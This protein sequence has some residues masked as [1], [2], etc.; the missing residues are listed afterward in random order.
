MK[1]YW[2]IPVVIAALG[3]TGCKNQEQA[4]PQEEQ[5]A[6]VEVDT[7]FNTQNL[8]LAEPLKY[9]VLFN[10]GDLVK[11]PGKDTM[12]TQKDKNDFMAYLPIDGSSTHGWLWTN[13]EEIVNDDNLLDGGGATLLEIERKDGGEWSVIGTPYA[14]D[15]GPVHGT[16]NN[17]LGGVTPWGNVI[18]SE[19]YEPWSNKEI[20]REGK[21]VRDT[22]DLEGYPRYMSYGWMVEVDVKQK[23][24]LR[25]LYAMG[26][27]SHEGAL[28]MPDGK[29]V[30][31]MDDEAPG[32]FFKFVADKANDYAEGQLYAYQQ[33]E[34]LQSGT[35]LEMPRSR[36]SLNYARD[37]ALKRGATVFIRLE[38]I[39]QAGDGRFILTETGRD[40]ADLSRAVALGGKIAKHNLPFVDENHVL[41]DYH[42]RILVFD[43][44]TNKVSTLL[45]GG[46]AA[47]ASYKVM[48]NPDNLSINLK[49]NLLVI[50]ED[51]NESDQDRVPPHAQGY[52]TNEIYALDL[53]IA[54]PTLD[55]LVRVAVI[56]KNAEST[57]PCWT[58]DFSSWFFNVQHPDPSNPKPFERSATVSVIGWK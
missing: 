45:A 51:N 47:K 13:H 18:T 20:H 29:T 24:A 3:W 30:Y 44:Q 17:C 12:V 34:D 21:G 35:W 41:R 58:P 32:I 19:E 50:H 1:F 4:P 25:K 56:P 53:G 27:F 57:G 23:K 38:D 42:G 33:S 49:R 15:F 40:K 37:M 43:A 7:N 5:F 16:Y 9:K 22:S 46:K 28:C 2:S 11:M 6:L 39:E 8:L 54:N 26:R 48:S 36:D 55:D 14:V 10:G 31:L 52:F